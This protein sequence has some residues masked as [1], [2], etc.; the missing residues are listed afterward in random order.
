M[1]LMRQTGSYVGCLKIDQREN[2][3]M[4]KTDDPAT[5]DQ[6]PIGLQIIGRRFDDELIVEILKYL[7]DTTERGSRWA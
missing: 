5:F 3:N 4:F 6:M 2:A 7:Q 1:I